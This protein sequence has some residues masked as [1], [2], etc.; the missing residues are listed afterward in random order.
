MWYT[1]ETPK[2]AKQLS[3]HLSHAAQSVI[4]S[5]LDNKAIP[6]VPQAQP[7]KLKLSVAYR[8]KP[9]VCQQFSLQLSQ[10][11]QPRVCHHLQNFWRLT[12]RQ[13]DMTRYRCFVSYGGTSDW[14]ARHRVTGAR[15]PQP[16]SD[17]HLHE[18]SELQIMKIWDR[19]NL[20]RTDE[21]RYRVAPQLKKCLWSF[22]YTNS[23]KHMGQW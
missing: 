5:A 19:Q 23:K 22:Q 20:R 3:L 13:T 1:E 8:R 14:N 6:S 2:C 15:T 11:M 16:R 21:A 4:S 17:K 9:Q 7:D 12:N 10:A 18:G